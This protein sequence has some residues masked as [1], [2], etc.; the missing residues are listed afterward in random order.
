MA[1][2]SARGKERHE[3]ERFLGLAGTF[4]FSS[5]WVSRLRFS[6]SLSLCRRQCLV[7]ILRSQFPPPPSSS[8]FVLSHRSRFPLRFRRFSLLSSPLFSFLSRTPLSF[9]VHAS[10]SRT[11]VRTHVRRGGTRISIFDRAFLSA[12]PRREAF[13][14]LAGV[15]SRFSLLSLSFSISH[16]VS[17]P[18]AVSF[19]RC[20]G[21]SV[22]TIV[23]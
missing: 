15:L 9:S 10:L 22:V 4:F 2:G 1:E 20:N 3:T 11:Y 19:S 21:A 5:R 18:A 12:A 17:R 14:A 8:T 6:L 23:V 7:L 16:F 13:A